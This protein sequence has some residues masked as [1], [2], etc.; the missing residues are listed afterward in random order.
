MKISTE[1]SSFRSWGGNREILRLLKDSGFDAY[2]FSMFRG[3]KDRIVDDSHYIREAESLREYAA[4]L[5]I[6]CNQSH[7]PFPTA[8]PGDDAF[9]AAMFDEI[10][11]A[12]EVSGALGAKVCVV[13]PCNY[14]TAEQNAGLYTRFEPF[15]RRA[16]VKIGVEN[17]W[18]WK[19]GETHACA[20]ACSEHG[21][22]LRHLTL[23][24]EDVF[25]AC[26]DIG[27][28]EMAGLNTSAVQMIETLGGRLQAIHLHDN[29]RVHDNHELPYSRNISFGPVIGALKKIGYRGD[30]TLEASSFPPRFPAALYPA[31]ARLMAGVADSFRTAL[32]EQKA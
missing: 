22:F 16:G 8:L 6:V 5:G 18:N 7:A 24:P 12:I 14:Y 9:N 31:V 21:D 15:A 29:D 1:I 2:D 28:A 27:H 20:A 11:R 10:V 23:L 17:M 13:H 30:I 26:L 32:A 19:E 4:A 25:V 3:D